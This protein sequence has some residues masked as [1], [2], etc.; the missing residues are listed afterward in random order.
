MGKW[1]EKAWHH[2]IS[3]INLDLMYGLKGQNAKTI[4]HDL[5]V[6]AQLAPQQVTLYE[7]R[8]NMLGVP[9]EFTKEELFSQY[10]LYYEGL[11]GMGYQAIFGQ[12]TFSKNAED[13]GLSSY[14]RSRM[15]DGISYKGFGISAQSMSKD[16]ISYNIGKNSKSIARIVNIKSFSEEFTY[17]LP[18]EEVLSK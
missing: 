18:K 10:S 7:L 2:G 11:T 13:K 12:N 14:L 17:I 9:V 4:N 8:T 3:K 1:M 5:Q 15:I 6:I 16:G